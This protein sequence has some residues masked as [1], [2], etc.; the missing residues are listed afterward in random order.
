MLNKQS[1]NSGDNNIC[2]YVESN[3]KSYLEKSKFK[4]GYATHIVCEAKCNCLVAELFGI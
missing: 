4:N 1:S 3:G 2:V